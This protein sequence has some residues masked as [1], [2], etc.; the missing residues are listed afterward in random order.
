M[1]IVSVQGVSKRFGAVT[2]L[3]GVD[4]AFRAGEVTGLVGENG[5]GKSTLI[6]ILAGAE[7]PTAGSV[8]LGGEQLPSTTGDVIAAGLSVI[9]QELTDVPDMTL[10]DNVLLGNLSSRGGL[11]RRGEN[12]RRAKAGLSRVGLGELDL[13]TP[14]RD[15]TISQRQL[16]EIARCL[17]RDTRV[18]ILDEPTSSLPERDVET[19]LSVVR[20][21]RDEGIAILYVTH[22]LDELF[23]VADRVVVLR[24]GNLVGDQPIG[25]WDEPSLVRSM[26]AKELEQ[27]YPWRPRDVGEPALV[28]RGLV[29][30]GVKDT[31]IHA[32]RGEVVG[33]VGL[34][35]S[36]RTELMKA[37]GGVAHVVSGEVSVA[38]RRVR[39]GSIAAAR[40]AGVVYVPEDRKAEGLVLDASVRSNIAMGDYAP[41][42]RRGLLRS[43][44]MTRRA[45]E[46]T[47]KY[48]VKLGSVHQE[49]GKLSGGNQQ[50]V[51]VGRV[52]EMSPRVVLFDDPTRGVDI[53]AKSGIYEHV[54]TLAEKGS[55]VM[56]CSSDTDEVLAVADRVYVLAAGRVVGEFARGS[57]DREKILHLAAGGSAVSEPP[58]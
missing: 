57:F 17:V 53:G 21:L 42:S 55:A 3:D 50:K 26:L 44:V 29:A 51:I 20:T 38:G 28:T 32:D 39:T 37:V 48:D 1:P 23:D 9:Y 33:L 31:S 35:G 52:S 15:L 7:T 41:V 14:I 12:R 24:D 40:S 54:F 56:V 5:A 6:K 25:Q 2:V 47:S 45:Q 13:R 4:F 19:L 49:I 36:G 10:L 43:G 27:A 16:A 34:A 22:H 18:L 46:I 8:V 58:A 30:R 11:T